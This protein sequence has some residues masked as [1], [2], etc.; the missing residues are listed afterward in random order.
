M[1]NLPFELLLIIEDQVRF[2]PND[3]EELQNA[4]NQWCGGE[5]VTQY[6]HISIWNTS[7]IR[8]MSNLFNWKYGFNDSINNWNVSQVTNMSCMFLDA[9]KF[10]QPLCHWNVSQV[11]DMSHMFNGALEFNQ[12]IASW[13][14]SQVTDMNKMFS[15]AVEFN[16]PETLEST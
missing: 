1:N 3:R 15:Y 12:P 10:N 11:T 16:Q 4:V 13:D 7:L 6:G 9:L 14:V 2:K 8:D 5:Y